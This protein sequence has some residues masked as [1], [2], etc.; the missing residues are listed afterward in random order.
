MGF[1][2]PRVRRLSWNGVPPHQELALSQTEAEPRMEDMESVLGD[3]RPRPGGRQP[4]T[5]LSWTPDRARQL[6]RG[7]EPVVGSLVWP[8]L[9]PG[10]CRL[11]ACV[12]GPPP[13]IPHSSRNPWS[14]TARETPARARPAPTAQDALLCSGPRRQGHTRSATQPFSPRPLLSLHTASWLLSRPDRAPRPWAEGARATVRRQRLSVRN[15]MEH[16]RRQPFSPPEEGLTR[17]ERGLS[18]GPTY[19]SLCSAGGRGVGVHFTL[20]QTGRNTT[21]DTPSKQNQTE[22][23]ASVWSGTRRDQ[24]APGGTRRE[25]PGGTR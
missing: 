18:D 25:G 8:L 13:T 16:L 4:G 5:H 12:Q 2:S 7:P 9:Q 22:L 6:L 20:S 21:H 15:R 3:R 1:S 17:P 14:E 23:C 24:E 19:R 11:S 10:S